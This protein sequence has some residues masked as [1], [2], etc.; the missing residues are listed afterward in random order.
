MLD[1]PR[2]HCGIVGMIGVPDSALKTY[3]GL[4]A[5]QHRGQESAGIVVSDGIELIERK[6]LGLVS[7]V[8]GTP[9]S[10]KDMPGESAIGHVL[11][12]TTGSTSIANS[13]P[14][15]INYKRGTIAGAHNG[16]LVNAIEL[17][18][19]MEGEGSIFRT[20]T[21]TEVVLHL[22][23][24]SPCLT[25]PEGIADALSQVRGAFC[26]VFLTPE[27]LV[28]VRDPAGVRPLGITHTEDGGTVIASESCAFD[29][30]SLPSGRSLLP[31][32]MIIADRS[33][34][35]ESIF[36]F[37]SAEPAP[38]IFEFIYFSRPDSRI[39]DTNVDKIRRRMG[40]V[41]AM[42]HPAD[43]DIVISVPDSS[44]TAALGYANESGLP[45]EFGLI[46]NHYIGRTF[47]QP[48]QAIRDFGARIKYNPVRGVLNGKRVVVVDDSIVRGTTSK[49]LVSM[50]REAGASE[51]HLRI[52]S[53]PIEY[54]CH[55]GIDT[56][57]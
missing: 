27:L 12:S 5:L 14:F 2:E 25:T 1:I 52:A 49:A 28:A 6:G 15:T 9:T 17:R 54:P 16:N 29:L 34:N 20:S 50:I 42:E 23:A 55:Y 8:F 38:C 13:Q 22:L 53:P 48:R 30:L 18:E 40:R 7:E 10:L 41:L 3:M 26:F 47:I 51:V 37:K 19:R 39:F 11:Y 45:F 36:P 44:N 24:R 56:P 43:A 21:D 32:E 31:G 33:G 57:T 35:V 46:R 4:Y